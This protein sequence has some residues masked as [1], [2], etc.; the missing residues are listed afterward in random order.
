MNEKKIG[1]EQ[2]VQK[3]YDADFCKELGIK[4]LM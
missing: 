2:R 1:Y 3:Y 4:R